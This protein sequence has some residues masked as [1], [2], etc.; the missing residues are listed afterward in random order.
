MFDVCRIDVRWFSGM[1]EPILP[2]ASSEARNQPK[3]Q[4]EESRVE[5]SVEGTG[6]R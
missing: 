3:R 5:E 2:G 6:H 1:R 4:E